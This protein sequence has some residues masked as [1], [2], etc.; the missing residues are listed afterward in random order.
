M[1]SII[2]ELYN[3]N[4]GFSEKLKPTEKYWE[5]CKQYDEV[6]NKLLNGTTKEQNELLNELFDYGGLC[7][8]E[9]SEQH[10]I[11]GFKLGFRIAVEV[12]A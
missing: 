11:E 4:C 8:G 2:E 7:A 5:I 1:K 10:F 9:M 3:D 12:L 6:F